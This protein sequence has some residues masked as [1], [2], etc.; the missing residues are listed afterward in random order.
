MFSAKVFLSVT[1]SIMTYSLLGRL[2]IIA[3]DCKYIVASY[4]RNHSNDKLNCLIVLRILH[5]K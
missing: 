5:D 3:S 1:V 4:A 2:Y